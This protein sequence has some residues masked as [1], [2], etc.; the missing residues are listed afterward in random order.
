LLHFILAASIVAAPSKAYKLEQY[1]LRINPKASQSKRIARCIV[2]EAKRHKVPVEMLGAIAHT[3]S[4]FRIT[5]RGQ[6]YERGI[7][8]VWPWARYWGEAWSQMLQH[9]YGVAGYPSVPWVK[10][11]RKLQIKA[12]MDVCISAYLAA[13]LLA[14][15]LGRCGR[16]SARCG[17]R[18]NSGGPKVR[19]GYVWAIRRRMTTRT[20]HRS[21]PIHHPLTGPSTGH[22]SPWR[23]AS[24]GRHP[25]RPYR[26]NHHGVRLTGPYPANRVAAVQRW[27][28]GP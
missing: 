28:A 24:T 26:D 19:P 20:P 14:Y 8:Q 12:S 11:G 10:L 25:R 7:Y 15:H 17:A 4:H 21:R 3:E 16:P 18:Y 23:Q 27:L 6:W 2:R 5:A 13:H 1:I 22:P 9:K